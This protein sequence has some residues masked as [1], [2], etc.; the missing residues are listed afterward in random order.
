MQGG[1]AARLALIKRRHRELILGPRERIAA[2]CGDE[3]DDPFD[4][5]L[6]ADQMELV[7]AVQLGRF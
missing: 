7:E 6:D 5:L 2:D 3:F 1:S 4:E